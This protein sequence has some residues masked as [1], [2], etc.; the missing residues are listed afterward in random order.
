MVDFNRKGCR[1]SYQ[2]PSAKFPS[3]LAC[4]SLWRIESWLGYFSDGWRAMLGVVVR[5]LL[6]LCVS[7]CI[8]K[9]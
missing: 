6:L 3:I 8:L 1:K 4:A 2:E 7:F 9:I 5:R